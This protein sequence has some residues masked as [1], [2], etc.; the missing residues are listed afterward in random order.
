MGFLIYTSFINGITSSNILSHTADL[1]E[2]NDTWERIDQIS[3]WNALF[4]EELK[5]LTNVS[6]VRCIGT[7]LAFDVNTE[8]ETTYF[9]DLRDQAFKYCISNGVFLRP[10]GNVLFINPPYSITEQEY[11]KVKDVILAFLRGLN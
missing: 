4:L 9:S 8:K 7:I 1:F 3:N 5:T 2:Q 6:N 10:L 11:K